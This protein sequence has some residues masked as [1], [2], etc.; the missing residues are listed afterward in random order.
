MRLYKKWEGRCT[1]YI[2]GDTGV[3][4]VVTPVSPEMSLRQTLSLSFIP[5]IKPLSQGRSQ[6][7]DKRNS[8]TYFHKW[9]GL[10][11][12]IPPIRHRQQLMFVKWLCIQT[13]T[14]TITFCSQGQYLFYAHKGL[15]FLVSYFCA[16]T[17]QI[18]VSEHFTFAKI[19]RPP[20]RFGTSRCWL[21]SMINTHVHVGHSFH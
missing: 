13:E 5:N 16:E 9:C 3:I 20:D 2:S 1:H 18:H 19:I 14:N 10:S 12:H 6:I 15:V 11:S 21:N 4:Y 8:K 7:I 17:C